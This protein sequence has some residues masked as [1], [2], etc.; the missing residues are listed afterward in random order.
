[1]KSEKYIQN[2]SALSEE[3]FAVHLTDGLL[4]DKL[5]QFAAEYTLSVEHLADL[6]VRRFVD[7][8]ELM[9]SLRLGAPEKL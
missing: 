1:M 2:N 4:Y 9:R 7:D 5:H 8:I 3:K 6:A